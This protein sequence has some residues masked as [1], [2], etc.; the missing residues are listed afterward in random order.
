MDDNSVH[1]LIGR[2]Y[3][4]ALDADAWE[5]VLVELTDA[6]G[7]AQVMMGLHDVEAGMSRVIAPRMDP[8]DLRSYRDHWGTGDIL[9]RRT[10]RAP[11]GEILHAERF[12]PRNEFVRTAIFNEWHRPQRL[13]AAGLGVNLY[14]VNG[15]PAVCGIKAPAHR[16]EFSSEVVALF[17]TVAPHLARS[18]RLQRRLAQVGRARDAAR[19]AAFTRPIGVIFVDSLQQVVETD[20]VARRL[21]DAGDGLRLEERRLRAAG[22]GPTRRLARLIDSCIGARTDQPAAGGALRV[23]R[24]PGRAALR[25]EVDPVT[26]G[27]EG[28]RLD[29]LTLSSPAAIVTVDDPEQRLVILKRRWVEMY[30]FTPAETALAAE[31]LRGDGRTAA[32]RRLGIAVGTARTHLMRIFDK[33]GVKRQAELVRLLSEDVRRIGRHKGSAAVA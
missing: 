21:L 31:I 24:G 8:E 22:A 15:L 27:P 33:A 32:A 20:H 7:G 3:D 13:G 9:W 2:I 25:L 17:T 23:E 28:R 14:S 10:N 29:W 4:A 5:D 6:V 18:V 1:G 19:Q 16:D 11:V 30:G 12:V 26:S